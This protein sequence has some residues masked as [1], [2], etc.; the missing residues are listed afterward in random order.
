MAARG[1]KRNEPRRRQ[2][3][4][5]PWNPGPTSAPAPQT[6]PLQ[7]EGRAP[8]APQEPPPPPAPRETYKLGA[9]LSGRLWAAR[10]RRVL[11]TLPARHPA[12]AAAA[13]RGGGG[14]GGPGGGA[15]RR[16][17]Q[18][19][20]VPIHLPRRSGGGRK[21]A[22]RQD[23]RE[24]LKD[25]RDGPPG[26]PPRSAGRISPTAAA[27]AAAAAHTSENSRHRGPRGNPPIPR[28]EVT[29]PPWIRPFRA[30][31]NMIGCAVRSF[32]HSTVQPGLAL[33]VPHGAESEWER[34]EPPQSRVWLV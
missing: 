9:F 5:R 8:S 4:R 3:A 17:V 19:W 14:V 27:G 7:R 26:P 24:E 20:P 31:R 12:V 34:G 6:R 22:A 16:L 13:E 10:R 15:L 2:K 11:G 25:R 23:T 33:R 28:R 21:A 1:S 32:D 30:Q 18:P 29:D